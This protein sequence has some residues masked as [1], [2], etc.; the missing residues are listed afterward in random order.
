MESERDAHLTAANQFSDQ[1]KLISKKSEDLY[2][3]PSHLAANSAHLKDYTDEP[4]EF[5]ND[6]DDKIERAQYDGQKAHQPPWR[7]VLLNYG[8]RGAKHLRNRKPNEGISHLAQA[9]HIL[10]MDTADRNNGGDVSN[11][12]SNNENSNNQQSFRD[13][14]TGHLNQPT[15]ANDPRT[16]RILSKLHKEKQ[17]SVNDDSSDFPNGM[18]WI[19]SNGEL[20][21]ANDYDAL[22]DENNSQNK[23]SYLRFGRYRRNNNFVALK[24]RTSA[25][26]Q[27]QLQQEPQSRQKQHLE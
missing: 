10:S 3:M 14:A 23:R 7:F 4:N 21:G 16:H 18:E 19:N 9:Q 26:Q 11:D 20:N 13:L 22:Y 1:L 17:T 25:Q 8:G 2:V 6:Y 27:Q 15:V 24:Q 12:N 5:E